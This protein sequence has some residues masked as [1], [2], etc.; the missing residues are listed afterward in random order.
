MLLIAT[1][2]SFVLEFYEISAIHFVK[3]IQRKGFEYL[4]KKLY[5]FSFSYVLHC[6]ACILLRCLSLH[7]CDLFCV[8]VC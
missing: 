4:F 2:Y 6:S 5:L 1:L 3:Y 7:K 8:C